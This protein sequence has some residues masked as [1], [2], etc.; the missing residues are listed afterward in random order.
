MPGPDTHDWKR[1]LQRLLPRGEPSER[2]HDDHR[3]GRDR[4]QAPRVRSGRRDDRE[5]DRSDS[6]DQKDETDRENDE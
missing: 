6:R 2:D 3:V 1:Q 5:V 4:R